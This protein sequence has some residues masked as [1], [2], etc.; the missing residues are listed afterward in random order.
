M[1]D[2]ICAAAAC[3]DCEHVSEVLSEGR[4]GLRNGN[5]LWRAEPIVLELG[6][7]THCIHLVK[8]RN[9]GA[10]KPNLVPS[11]PVT[12]SLVPQRRTESVEWAVFATAG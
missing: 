11:V 7:A 9:I 1:A 5:P 8:E 4:E 6:D 3:A 10:S 12:W 2:D